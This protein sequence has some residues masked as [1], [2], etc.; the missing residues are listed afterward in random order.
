MLCGALVHIVFHRTMKVWTNIVT[1]LVVSVCANEEE[2]FGRRPRRRRNKLL[3]HTDGKDESLF[4]RLLDL[5]AFEPPDDFFKDQKEIERVLEIG[6]LSMSFVPSIRVIG[7]SKDGK[8]KSKDGKA[9]DDK[10]KSKEGWKSKSNKDSKNVR[11]GSKSKSG[12][13]S[14]GK[15]GQKRTKDADE[16]KMSERIV[17][18][19]MEKGRRV[20]GIGFSEAERI[21]GKS[22]DGKAKSGKA[23]AGKKEKK[24]SHKE[25]EKLILPYSS[26]VAKSQSIPPNRKLTPAPSDSPVGKSGSKSAAK[27]GA[28]G[29]S[30]RY[31]V[32]R[33]GQENTDEI[34]SWKSEHRELGDHCLIGAPFVS[35]TST[36]GSKDGTKSGRKAGSKEGTKAGSKEGTKSGAKGGIDRRDR[37]RRR[38]ELGLYACHMSGSWTCCK[39]YADMGDDPVCCKGE[40]IEPIAGRIS[41]SGETNKGPTSTSSVKNSDGPFTSGLGSASRGPSSY[42]NP[43]HSNDIPLPVTSPGFGGGPM[44]VRPQDPENMKVEHDWQSNDQNKH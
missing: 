4:F 35:A 10:G 30:R 39:E 38:T 7:K 27:G 29:N 36:A 17:A 8:A 18:T 24:V 1:L 32:R 15:E 6:S 2:S 3:E 37:G 23:K 40:Y 14:E 33:R 42:V 19:K 13:A 16:I 31:K 11:T 20:L 28:K 21:E 34:V 12:K 9:K 5:D 25:T 43:S 26:K 22:K 41:H 44:M